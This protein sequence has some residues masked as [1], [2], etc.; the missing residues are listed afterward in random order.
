MSLAE[1][2]ISLTPDQIIELGRWGLGGILAGGIVHAFN[3][4]MSGIT[5]QIDLTIWEEDPSGRERELQKL[6]KLCDDYTQLVHHFTTV[7]KT[8][9]QGAPI[10]GAGLVDSLCKVLA[11]IY[12]REGWV[13]R[14]EVQNSGL[15][16]ER[17]DLFTQSIMH[18]A[19][20]MRG[21]EL[22]SR[23]QKVEGISE[24]LRGGR[25]YSSSESMPPPS[26]S[27]L[28]QEVDKVGVTTIILESPDEEER[29]SQGSG[30]NKREDLLAGIEAFN[31]SERKHH[32]FI[33]KLI[34]EV[35]EDVGVKVEVHREGRAIKGVINWPGR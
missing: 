16:I 5:G 13:W 1:K 9:S 2:K 32:L 19:L 12:R 25:S 29:C 34:G 21:I 8:L 31:A 22:E 26:M 20:G 15:L 33:V 18:C 4:I 14:S 7:I 28:F 24:H 10:D 11:R 35:F 6:S 27:F 23:E 30:H 17:G 3:N